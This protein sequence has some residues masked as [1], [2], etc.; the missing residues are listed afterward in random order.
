MEKIK[1]YFGNDE[2][3]F[4]V[5][6]FFVN[7]IVCFFGVRMCINMVSNFFD[8]GFRNGSGLFKNVNE[9]YHGLTV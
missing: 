6:G 7:S 8:L 2:L 3:C 5:I 9:G 4:R 1:V